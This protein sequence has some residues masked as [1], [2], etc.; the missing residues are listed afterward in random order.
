MS[1][2]DCA[3]RPGAVHRKLTNTHTEWVATETPDTEEPAGSRGAVDDAARRA[4]GSV[5][6]RAREQAGH[7][8]TALAPLM[9]YSRS[10]LSKIESGMERPT[11]P[12]VDRAEQIL[13]T[14]DAIRRAYQTYGEIAASV[15]AATP[16][17]R[18]GDRTP[19]QLPSPPG[20]G[21]LVVLREDAALRYEMGRYILV[22]KRLIQNVGHEAVNGYPIRVHVDKFPDD[23]G[24][25]ER[26]YRANPLRWPEINF[27]AWLGEG[28]LVRLKAA[29][30]TKT[31]SLIEGWVVF[32]D[33]FGAPTTLYPGDEAMIEYEYSVTHDKWGPWFQ[34]AIRYPTHELSVRLDFPVALGPHVWGRERSSQ[35][36]SEYRPF[37][38][39]IHCVTKGLRR[40]YTWSI[41]NPPLHSRYR[42]EWRFE[43]APDAEDGEGA[44][45]TVTTRPSDVMAALG[46]VQRGDAALADAIR[47]FDLPAEAEEAQRVCDHLS[48]IAD[49]VARLHFFRTG[50]GIAAPQI[51]VPR[52]AAIYRP[53][54]GRQVVL[55]NPRIVYSSPETNEDSEGCLSF[56][57]WRGQVTRPDVIAVAYQQPSGVAECEVFRGREARDIHHEID[58]LAGVLYIDRMASESL[59]T[60]SLH[61]RP[62]PT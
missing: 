23:E 3:A 11:A 39:K 22:Q 2:P 42:M 44:L 61:L 6:R 9:G 40:I 38:T 58:H 55:L 49:K 18:S 19:S 52:A 41:Q 53:A 34:R 43:T 62:P 50:M 29:T 24:R 14:G 4:F 10:Y 57:D 13:G 33:D 32:E 46:I 28:R 36:P 21:D 59:L 31:D 20:A 1:G 5:I 16:S 48:T 56:F 54:D 47:P 37:R 12:F 26:F 30:Q 7:S 8:Q 15:D 27:R 51:G 25:S 45:A 60:P 35:H 17:A